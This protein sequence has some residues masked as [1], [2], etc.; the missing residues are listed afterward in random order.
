MTYL[1]KHYFHRNKIQPMLLGVFIFFCFVPQFVYGPY[2]VEAEDDFAY[3]RIFYYLERESARKSLFDN[4]RSIDILAPQAYVVTNEGDLSGSIKDDVLKFCADNGIG[5][6]PLVTNTNFN[7]KSLRAVL[8]NNK[9]QKKIIDNM[10]EEAVTL[11]YI[12]WQIDFEQMDVSYKH[13]FNI[14]VDKLAR[15]LHKKGKILSV[16]VVSKISDIPSDYKK[17]LWQDLIGVYDYDSLGQSVD[18]VSI[19]SYDAPDSKGAIAPYPWLM[20]VIDYAKLHL[21]KEK[22][23]LGI[24]L[25]YWKWDD[26]REKIV[27]IG[28]YQGL[29]TALG[30]K[31][32]LLGYDDKDKAPFMQF[33]RDGKS[34][35]VWYENHRSIEEKIAIIK[36]EGFHGFSAWVLGLE[37]PSIHK[38]IY[39]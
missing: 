12:G 5:V 3:K 17:T 13:S 25:Y 31:N 1:L 16:A 22:I 7:D 28:G 24:G 9:N 6:M 27:G 4:P 32:V 18:F 20:Q 14:F 10:V 38:V 33:V 29:K 36:K 21:P 23:S 2:E 19:M 11:N 26:E 15:E 34:Y 37:V 30:Y 35:S 39:K 8:K